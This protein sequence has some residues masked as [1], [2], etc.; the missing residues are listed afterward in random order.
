MDRSA[1][2][3]IDGSFDD[4]AGLVGLRTPPSPAAW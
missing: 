1:L 4:A 2:G 3:T